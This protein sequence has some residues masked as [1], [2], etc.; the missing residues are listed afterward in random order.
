MDQECA[1]CCGGFNHNFGC[2]QLHNVE[3][4]VLRDRCLDRAERTLLLRLRLFG[5]SPSGSAEHAAAASRGTLSAQHR[6]AI[7]N[8]SWAQRGV[9]RQAEVS[10]RPRTPQTLASQMVTMTPPLLPPPVWWA[11]ATVTYRPYTWPHTETSGVIVWSLR[12]P[13]LTPVV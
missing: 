8:E 12:S 4:L 7:F 1:L 3:E 5:H 9:H 11:G 2:T 13:H 6:T 10:T